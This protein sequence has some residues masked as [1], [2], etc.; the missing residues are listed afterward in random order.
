MAQGVQVRARLRRIFTVAAILG[1]VYSVGGAG[2]V[3]SGVSAQAPYGVSVDVNTSGTLAVVPRTAI[4]LNTSVYDGDIT[5]QAVPGLLRDA[6]V[7]LLRFPGGS[8]SDEY[9][10]AT[11]TDTLYGQTEATDFDQFMQVA[12][13]SGA[14]AMITVNYGTGTPAEAAAW[15]K[16]AN[17][18]HHDNVRYWE[19]GNEVYGNGTYGSDWEVDA[20]CRV[21]SAAG[22]APFN[23]GGGTLSPEKPNT[24][25][26]PTF[27]CGP[28]QYAKNVAR[29]A[30]AMKSV[31]PGIVIGVVLTA[32][33]NW[34]D[35]N[36]ISYICGGSPSSPTIPDCYWDTTVLSALARL[37]VP[38]GFADVHWY[39][40]NPSNV[41]G[42]TN[43]P[44]TNG[45]PGAAPNDANL[46]AT[47]SQIPGMVSTLEQ[48]AARD[49]GHSLPIMVTE[50]NSV[51]A[52]PGRQSVSVVNAL[53][54]DQDYLTWL[55]NGVQN[56]DWWQ[57]HNGIV[58]NGDNT[59]TD[60][61]SQS[62]GGYPPAPLY[63][64]T[65]YGDY[66]VLANGSCANTPASATLSDRSECEPRADTPFPAYYGL[67][68]LSRFIQPGDRLL[69][70]SSSS[71]LVQAF[72]AKGPGDRLRV[73]VI[74]DDPT[75]SHLVSIA[76]GRS[77]V[78]PRG[79]ALRYGANMAAPAP[80]SSPSGTWVI[81]PYT[82]TIFTLGR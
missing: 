71:S 72:A 13:S 30:R 19:I 74:N 32:P 45:S 2:V 1:I 52:S 54:L 43:P 28:L 18:E 23:P 58:T 5:D 64:H 10:W 62:S 77:W 17:I 82:V 70:A 12:R 26:A 29:F 53:F 81:P 39:P 20:R 44:T 22:A 36:D 40:Q 21:S 14:Q 63:G 73:M 7:T 37:H 25:Q 27:N 6:G 78:T 4:G 33:N 11:N 75:T 16:Y 60:Y 61:A 34:P 68:M 67:E 49:Y 41:T 79:I 57:L 46:L 3:T 55:D 42:Y 80:V 24:G 35:D 48:R 56:V 69:S 15:V 38:I 47:D 8:E 50:T 59:P 9:N 51:S 76:V 65:L 31:D 66:G